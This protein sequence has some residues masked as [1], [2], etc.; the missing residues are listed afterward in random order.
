M[1]DA[2]RDTTHRASRNDLVLEDVFCFSIQLVSKLVDARYFVFERCSGR[3]AEK[4]A[5][6]FSHEGGSVGRNLVD[7]FCEI[8]RNG[9]VCAHTIKVS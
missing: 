6:R 2:E 5:N 9:D 8:I 7:L 4:A 3:V 1:K